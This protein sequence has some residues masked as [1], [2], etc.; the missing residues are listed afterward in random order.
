MVR[1]ALLTTV[2]LCGVTARAAAPGIGT[3]DLLARLID[4]PVPAPNWAGVKA[5]QNI[6]M[7]LD[8]TAGMLGTTAL[9]RRGSSIRYMV[10]QSPAAARADFAR[11]AFPPKEQT[12]AAFREQPTAGWPGPAFVCGEGLLAARP[13][14]RV[15]SCAAR[16]PSLALIVRVILPPSAT[17]AAQAPRE[18]LAALRHADAVAAAPTPPVTDAAVRLYR[19]L[20]DR[21]IPRVETIAE[22]LQGLTVTQDELHAPNRADGVIGRLTLAG[23]GMTIRYAVFGANARIDNWVDRAAAL[24]VDGYHA[25][26]EKDALQESGANAR[27]RAP[28]RTQLWASPGGDALCDVVARHRSLPL[29][30]RVSLPVR[31]TV[32]R[33]DPRGTYSVST[34]MFD[35]VACLSLAIDLADWASERAG[36]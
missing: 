7:K 26:G 24:G 31:A 27:L 4:D 2:L 34:D 16:H 15:V 10:Y 36:R 14:Q 22:R 32:R 11:Q 25:V 1:T 28:A 30:I 35:K 20:R 21:P 6:P 19:A 18:L 13:P 9:T 17:A 12:A 29:G 33:T 23:R 3:E 5:S 8:T